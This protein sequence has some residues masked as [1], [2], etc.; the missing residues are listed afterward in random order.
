MKESVGT[1]R[2]RVVFTNPFTNVDLVGEAT[3]QTLVLIIKDTLAG[4]KWM[5]SELVEIAD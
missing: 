5:L 2:Y 1:R 3:E 4:G